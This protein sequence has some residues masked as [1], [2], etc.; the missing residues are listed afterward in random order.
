MT[1][2]KREFDVS[3][4]FSN[5]NLRDNLSESRRF[6]IQIQ[7]LK[8]VLFSKITITIINQLTTLD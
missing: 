2:D 1:R 6:V 5:E 8:I 7:I 4:F 3:F